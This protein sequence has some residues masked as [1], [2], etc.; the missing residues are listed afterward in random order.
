MRN[1]YLKND[2]NPKSSLISPLYGGHKLPDTL[3]I[4]GEYDFF[5]LQDEAFSEKIQGLGTNVNFIQYNG[6]A[7][8][9]A[10][11]TGVY[12][13]AADAVMEIADFIENSLKN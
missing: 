8:A 7:H 11:L 5:R 10:H 4:V 2:E 12:D 6:M 9:F 3:L 1:Y 13:Q